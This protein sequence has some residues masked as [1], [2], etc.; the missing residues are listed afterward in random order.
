[1]AEKELT[2][3]YEYL[4]YKKFVAELIATF[5]KEGRGVFSKLAKSINVS[6]VLISQIFKGVKDLTID[7]AILTANFF[8]F[9]EL[10]TEYFVNLV[11]KARA[12]TPELR[13]FYDQKIFDI[14]NKSLDIKNRINKQEN[15]SDEAKAEFYS[16]WMYSAIRLSC[17]LE[18]ISNVQEITEFFNLHEPLVQEKVDFLLKNG[19]L[20]EEDGALQIGVNSTHL[21]KDNPLVHGHRKNWRLKAIDSFSN[22]NVNDLFYVAP[23]VVSEDIAVKLREKILQFIEE[24][25]KEVPKEAPETTYCL[26]IDFFNF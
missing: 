14:Q 25:Y 21:G 12:A 2:P 26:N 22:N 9:K 18:E 3:I 19:L 11:S 17:A 13:K 16:S 7:Q 6:S 10:E 23:M 24:L 15:I 4:D 8:E 5:P 1:M 20:K